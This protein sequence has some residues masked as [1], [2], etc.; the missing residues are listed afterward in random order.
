MDLARSPYVGFVSNMA[1]PVACH[2]ILGRS[3]CITTTL[4]LNFATRLDATGDPL[5][6]FFPWNMDFEQQLDQGQPAAPTQDFLA[7][8]KV[9]P[10]IPYLKNDVTV[11]WHILSVLSLF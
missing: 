8:V 5:A 11:S 6:L 4:S 3:W 2:F 1:T 9:F 7:T 10:L